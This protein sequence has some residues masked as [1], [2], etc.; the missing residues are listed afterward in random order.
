MSQDHQKNDLASKSIN[1][2]QLFF[3]TPSI[4]KSLKSCL[5][6]ITIKISIPRPRFPEE[7]FQIPRSPRNEKMAFPDSP[8]PRGMKSAGELTALIPAYGTL[9]SQELQSQFVSPGR[10]L[11]QTNK[12]CFNQAYV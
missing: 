4:T 12:Q 7:L 11:K 1:V 6:S 5:Y 3:E 10:P 2:S 9:S 8:I